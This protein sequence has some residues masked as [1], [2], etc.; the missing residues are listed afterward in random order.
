MKRIL[1]CGAGGSAGINFIHCLRMAEE[2]IFIVGTDINKWHL[3]LPDLDSRYI[4]P[5]CSDNGYIDKLNQIIDIENI[6]FVH[7]QPDVEVEVLSENQ[8]KIKAHTFLPAKRTVGICQNKIELNS[9]LAENNVPVPESLLINNED[10]LINA[11]SILKKKHEKIW[12][13]AIKGAGARASLPII[14]VK[15]GIMWIDYWGR[16]KETGYCDFMACEF[17]PGREFAF[18]SIWNNG[19]LVISAARER[20]E[21]IFGELTPS[22]QTSSPSTARVVY[23][24]DVNEIATQAVLSIDK[25]A[26]GVFCVDLKENSQGA[27]CVTEINA[28]R[29]FTTSNFFAALGA[30]MPHIYLKLAYDEKLPSLP[31]YNAT[32]EGFYWLRLMDKG[33]LL[34]K[35]GTW[36]SKEI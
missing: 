8:E 34:V 30:N 15:Q 21:Y 19:E 18:Q 27:P 29:F 26:T 12:L 17:L 31:R 33:P 6:E 16:M 24:D 11:I 25:K 10:D 20:L 1:V 13:R 2:N 14:D 23:R 3:E 22:G 7:S 36:R 32:P 4:V 35:E 9:I 28:G 5:K